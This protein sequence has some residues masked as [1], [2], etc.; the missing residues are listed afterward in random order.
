[1]IKTLILTRFHEELTR[2][3]ITEIPTDDPT[4]ASVVKIGRFQDDPTRYPISVAISPGDPED[5]NYRDGIVTLDQMH[6][7]GFEVPAR[8]IGG[9]SYWWRRGILQVQCHFVL[10][11]YPETIALEHAHNVLGRIELALETTY[12]ADL[13]DDFGEHAIVP[14]VYGNTF[15]ESGGPP[16]DYIWRGKV[17]WS[18]LTY[19][20]ST[21]Y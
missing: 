18:V 5:P 21:S 19:R 3:L 8:E 9:G 12:L 13:T 16:A 7:I 1:M 14:F 6:N 2:A 10:A 15:F 17:L 4:I 11:R 20:S